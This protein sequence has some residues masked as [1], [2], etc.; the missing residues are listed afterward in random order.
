KS[1][2]F[3]SLRRLHLF[4]NPITDRGALALVQTSN[5]PNMTVLDLPEGPFSQ[6]VEVA[7]REL[8]RGRRE[9]PDLDCGV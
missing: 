2:S 7:Y 1:S 4:A 5:L 6:E 8:T 3:P 9:P